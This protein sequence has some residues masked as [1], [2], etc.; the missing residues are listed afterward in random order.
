[1]CRGVEL[2]NGN[3]VKW[4]RSVGTDKS[5]GA[6][7]VS[8]S[9]SYTISENDLEKWI[10][11]CAIADD[12]SNWQR[13]FFVSRL[14]VAYITTDDGAIPSIHKEEHSGRMRIQGNAEFGLQYDGF[15][16]KIH[17][18][19]NS[20]INF[21]KKPWK[22]KLAKKTELFGMPKSKHWVLLANYLDESLM[23]NKIAYDFSGQL[24]LV[25]MHSTWVDVILNGEYQGC[26][27]LC[28]HI[29][30]DSNRVPVYN[31][32]DAA[33]SVAGKFAEK[34]SLT[35]EQEDELIE[36]L[37]QDLSWVTSDSVNYSGFTEKPSKLWKKF[38]NDISG[39]YLFELSTEYDEKS[40][41]TVSSGNLTTKIMINSPEMAVS[42]PDMMNICEKI[43]QDY[44]DACTSL[45]GYN[46]DGQHYSDLCDVD[47]MVAYWLTMEI[48]C[49][50]D[51]GAKS[52]YA[53]KDQGKILT[54]GPAWDFDWG[55]GSPVIRGEA[56]ADD[57]SKYWKPVSP[58]GFALE[59]H[60]SVSAFYREWADDPYFCMKLWET[61]WNC[62]SK[63]DDIVRDGGLIDQYAEYLKEAGAANE[64]KWKYRIGFSG[65][66][67]DVT[68]LKTYLKERFEW[69]DTQFKDVDT[70]VSCV[71]TPKSTNPY[72]RTK[73]LAL[74][75]AKWVLDGKSLD[76][77][78][79]LPSS[80]ST[81]SVYL[82][83]KLVDGA[84]V[85]ASVNLA[86]PLS[87]ESGAA[88]YHCVAIIGRNEEGEVVGCNYMI[89][90]ASALE[91]SIIKSIDPDAPDVP[92][93]WVVENV[94]NEFL[95]MK[96]WTS[97]Q[98]AQVLCANPS[99]FGKN[100]PLWH[101][102]VAGTSPVPNAT[103]SEFRVN[104]EIVEGRPVI[105]WTP[106]LKEERH[107]QIKGKAALDGD[108][109][110]PVQEGDRFF[111]VDVSL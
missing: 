86:I 111:K 79:T 7:C 67:G 87:E 78:I 55:V 38:S 34:H 64:E 57:G 85:G 36:Q 82:N 47:S 76:T 43:W 50:N 81:A 15:L 101:D 66:E 69:L 110:H 93:T 53:Y 54:W 100:Q 75:C 52:R 17:V 73:A 90:D 3:D 105:T 42:C 98:L 26:Y 48:F 41:F 32:E 102:Y 97:E 19:G 30:V 28:E 23:R 21:P 45:D 92:S 88:I 22:I 104:I 2:L 16:D 83:G 56:V 9:S 62:R 68:S 49:N 91:S 33:E 18:R 63:M 40:Q 59:K 61:Y 94:A 106:D 46:N 60:N 37:Q 11:V 35:S 10:K 13:E 71:S 80:V 1:M 58:K 65:D 107:Y 89:V 95:E 27:Q 29:R 74:S 31:W 14:P 108:E 5:F 103:N 70:L 96:N 51:S 25:Q 99:P 6:E 20:T 8:E 109:W 44:W 4:Y 72:S 24:G 84:S 12:G 39:G 77:K